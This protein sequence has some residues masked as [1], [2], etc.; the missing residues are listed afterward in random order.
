M[1]APR[2]PRPGGGGRSREKRRRQRNTVDWS[3]V[4]FGPAIRRKDSR[5][6]AGL[7]IREADVEVDDGPDPDHPN[8]KVRRAQRVDTLLRLVRGG[9]I[10][11][12]ELE[13]AETLRTHLERML[14]AMISQQIVHSDL[15]P[16]TRDW[17]AETQ[18]YASKFARDAAAAL[19]PRLWPPVLW[20]CLG[21][22]V[23]SFAEFQQIR[24]A[25][26]CECVTAGFEALADHVSG[27]R[28]RRAA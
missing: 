17:I 4:D 3:G 22:T 27:P 12:R 6:H 10:G 18:L 19:G 15:S 9:S 21:G 20:L 1:V 23:R 14:P 28:Y 13:A 5:D 7:V 24:L 11:R 25:T 2:F 16:F 26:G 8:R